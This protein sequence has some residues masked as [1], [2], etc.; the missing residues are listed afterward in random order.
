MAVL[1]N[2]LHL[3]SPDAVSS[4]GEL[5]VSELSNGFEAPMRAVGTPALNWCASPERSIRD[6]GASFLCVRARQPA[7]LRAVVL[8]LHRTN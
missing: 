3:D 5:T 2:S 6:Q 4:S 7:S 1:P 8:G